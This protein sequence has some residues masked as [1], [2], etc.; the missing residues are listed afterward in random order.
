MSGFVLTVPFQA[1]L[2][3]NKWSCCRRKHLHL[4]G[5]ILRLF[6]HLFLQMWGG[7]YH[8]LASTKTHKTTRVKE[9]WSLV[10]PRRIA[11]FAERFIC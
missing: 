6:G 11:Q 4:Y 5:D 9:R 1:F 2:S 10:Q 8:A 3:S 7:T